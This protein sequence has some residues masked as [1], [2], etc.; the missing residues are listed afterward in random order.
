MSVPIF[1]AGITA[2]YL[3]LVGFK[4]PARRLLDSVLLP[5]ALGL[6]ANLI[7]AFFWFRDVGEPAHFANQLSGAPHIW[8]PHILLALAVNLG[9]GFQFASVGFILIAA[10]FV[11]QSWGRATVPIHLPAESISDASSS[12]DEQ[13]STML[14]VWIVI[15]LVFLISVPRI[16][17]W[18]HSAWNPWAVRFID[19]CS[20]L[21]FVLLALGKRG[22]KMIPAMLRIPRSRYLAVALVVPAAIANIGPLASYLH[23]RVLWSA[24]EW[25]QH[26]PPS[27]S[28]FLGLPTVSSVWYFV[29]ARLEEIAWRGYLQPRFVRRYGLV[30][31]IFLVGVAWGAFHYFGDFNSHMTAGD[32]SLHLVTRLA[33]TVSLS[34]VLAWLTI[35]SDSILP[36]SVAHASY[37]IFTTS[38][39][40]PIHNPL[41]LTF[42][43]WTV[44]AFVLFHYFS[45]ASPC[46]VA[47]SDVRP[48]PEPEPSEV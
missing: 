25:G 45:P 10:F 33:N 13:R 16:A 26:V 28:S 17:M 6:V 24:H 21:V 23:A 8:E 31:G 38:W 46:S 41:W 20:L 35:R 43:L 36:A 18:I 32:V 40:L 34:Y 1:A 30:R 4:K 2:C 3:G 29:P 14:F 9:T 15:G 44:A 22:R 39:S 42:L 48:A 5:A 7:V 37:N 47:E 11:L 12:E 19:A 27:P